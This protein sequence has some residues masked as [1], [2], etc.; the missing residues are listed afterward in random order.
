[1]YLPSLKQHRDVTEPNLHL[2]SVNISC[3]DDPNNYGNNIIMNISLSK[4]S[5][6]KIPQ[7]SNLRC[8]WSDLHRLQNYVSHGWSSGRK[9]EQQNNAI[10][11]KKQCSCRLS[12]SSE[13]RAFEGCRSADANVLPIQAGLLQLSFISC[14]LKV[15]CCFKLFSLSIPNKFGMQNFLQY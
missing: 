1:M 15:S 7:I 10:N 9:N 8:K 3:L 5:P 11:P 2:V 13:N 12:G 14:Q 4:I 6:A